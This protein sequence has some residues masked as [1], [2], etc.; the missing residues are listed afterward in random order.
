MTTN[1]NGISSLGGAIDVWEG[2]QISRR[3]KQDSGER[4][5]QSL[6]SS[7]TKEKGGRGTTG[8]VRGVIVKISVLILG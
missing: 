4:G 8:G 3:P 6:S 5:Y 7:V 2:E 1:K